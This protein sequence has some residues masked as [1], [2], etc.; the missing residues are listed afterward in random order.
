[1]PGEVT[2]VLTAGLAGADDD[3]SL[4]DSDDL[5]ALESV[6][7]HLRQIE[8]EREAL[9]AEQDRF[10]TVLRG[11]GVSWSTISKACGVANIR[12]GYERRNR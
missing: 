2:A 7:G 4:L 6:A 8:V 9:V 11:Q 10:I 5:A 1:M 3:G 12:I